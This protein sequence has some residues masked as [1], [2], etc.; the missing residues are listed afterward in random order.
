MYYCKL[1]G[2]GIES[3]TFKF[4][5]M[6]MDHARKRAIAFLE[7]DRRYDRI[8]ISTWRTRGYIC[9]SP[10]GTPIYMTKGKSY[11]ISRHTGKMSRHEIPEMI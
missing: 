8:D 7:S 5:S 3:Q 6:D 4:Q 10:R 9:I 11:T 1:S 2:K